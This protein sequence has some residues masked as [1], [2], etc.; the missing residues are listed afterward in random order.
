[1]VARGGRD[2]CVFLSEEVFLSVSESSRGPVNPQRAGG[3]YRADANQMP[4]I[5]LALFPQH[6]F[7]HQQT[8]RR[9]PTVRRGRE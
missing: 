9:P 7:T 1:M 5:Y 8:F 6:A 4:L 3:E 2:L